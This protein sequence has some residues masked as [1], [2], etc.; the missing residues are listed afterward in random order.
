MV[1]HW[2]LN[3]SFLIRTASPRSRSP[4]DQH[5]AWGTTLE[6]CM[7]CRELRVTTAELKQ[8]TGTARMGSV[9]VV[10]TFQNLRH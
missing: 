3:M 7:A 9:R 10:N 6:D 1:S 8:L 2:C 5:Q 4:F